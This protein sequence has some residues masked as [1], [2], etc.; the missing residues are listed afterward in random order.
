MNISFIIN[1]HPQANDHPFGAG[2]DPR[3]VSPAPGKA[4]FGASASC[5]SVVGSFL[6]TRFSG[7]GFPAL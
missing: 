3:Y 7:C 2:G 5:Y 6:I 4:A 1:Y